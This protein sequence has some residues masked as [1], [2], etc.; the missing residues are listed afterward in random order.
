MMP[1]DLIAQIAHVSQK[2]C[3]QSGEP[4]IEYAGAIVSHLAAYPEDIEVFMR[5][6][7]GMLIDGRMTL[8]SGCLAHRC[9]DGRVRNSHEIRELTSAQKMMQ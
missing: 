6:G 2:L 3:Q 8:I 4:S 5:E 9:N 1:A 7:A